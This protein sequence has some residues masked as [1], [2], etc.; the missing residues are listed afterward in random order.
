MFLR[1]RQGTWV[2]EPHMELYAFRGTWVHEPHMEL[3]AFTAPRAAADF[4]TTNI[5][6]LVARGRRSRDYLVASAL[7]VV[8]C[9]RPQ[10]K[11]FENL[12]IASCFG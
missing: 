4:L 7:F 10:L 12:K 2:H 5:S 6:V 1:H 8:G 3:Y 11:I 9:L